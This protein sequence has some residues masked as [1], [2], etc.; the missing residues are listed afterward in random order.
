MRTSRGRKGL[1]ER[2]RLS[3]AA[4]R[5]WERAAAGEAEEGARRE[6]PA[7]TRAQQPPPA[8]Q[9]PGTAAGARRPFARV[10]DR[11]VHWED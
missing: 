7:W 4:G 10:L 11:C 8:R 3:E 1:G 9:A 6:P 5:P 2:E